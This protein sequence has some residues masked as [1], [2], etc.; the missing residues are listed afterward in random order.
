[1][2]PETDDVCIRQAAEAAFLDA[3]AAGNTVQQAA[4]IAGVGRRTVY[5]WR[6]TNPAFADKWYA[7]DPKY[8][9][10]NDL[11]AEAV[12]RAVH[13]VRKP[14]YRGGEIVGHTTDYSDS[15][16][17]FLLKAHFPEKYDSKQTGK[18]Q[19]G[20]GAPDFEGCIEGARDAL[21]RKFTEATTPQRA[22]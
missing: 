3:L 17:M 6:R 21:L 18:N 4:K 19:D 10:P 13:G 1:M 2:E 20:S 22:G 16:L 11:E 8:R 9:P 12:R 5:N 15:M 7:L 14:V